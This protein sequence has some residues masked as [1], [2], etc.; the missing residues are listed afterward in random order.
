[1]LSAGLF[2]FTPGPLAAE[3]PAAS[4]GA[5]Q[6]VPDSGRPVPV[7]S[8]SSLDSPYIPV[9]SW[10]Y[11][12]IMRLYGLGYVDSISLGMR[13][14]TRSAVDHMLEEAGAR[15]E[16]AQDY[17][18]ATTDEAQQIYRALNHELRQDTEGP[19]GR[20]RGLARLES[21]YTVAPIIS[22][23]PL[24]DSFHLGQ[25]VINNYGRPD[26]N[27]FNNYTGASGYATVGRF[28]LYVRGEA[29][30][31]PSG[32]GYSPALAQTLSGIDGT[33]LL[34]PTNQPIYYPQSTI[35]LGPVSNIVRGRFVEAYVS[36][37]VFNHEIALGKR[38]FWLGP[39]LGGSFAYSNNAENFYSFSINRVEPLS[40]PLLSRITGPFRYEFAIGGLHG[41]TYIPNPSYPGP[42][43]P[44]VSN[45]GDP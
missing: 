7:C 28:L 15:I 44:Y 37:H 43:Q 2:I 3:T 18:D 5:A 40:I 11:P 31:A 6:T 19:C 34:T 13:P 45:P 4:N 39:G 14:W 10:I 30:F 26:E 24:N 33:L 12:A 20:L 17:A 22:G 29:Q 41:H 16:D 42:G 8:P 32:V 38:D 25:T 21:V 36:T 1:M 23:T 9:D 35:P 27:G